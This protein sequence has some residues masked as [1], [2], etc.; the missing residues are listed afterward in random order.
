MREFKV[1][2]ARLEPRVP[3]A[4]GARGLAGNPQR[5]HR[6]KKE[7]RAGTGHAFPG[8]G[9]P[10]CSA[11]RVAERER[12][13]GPH[14]REIDVWQGCWPRSK[15]PRRRP[16]VSGHPLSSRKSEKKGKLGIDYQGSGGRS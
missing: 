8:H 9:N 14:T 3:R 11:G 1:A 5:L 6:W 10:R 13:I 12:K 15:P 4:E 16:V 7:F 2:A